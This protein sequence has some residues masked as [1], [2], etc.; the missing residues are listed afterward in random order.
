MPQM[1]NPIDIA[2]VV[3]FLAGDSSRYV[4]GAVIAAD[5]GWLAA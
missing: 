5:A 3:L 2:N 4:N 1:L